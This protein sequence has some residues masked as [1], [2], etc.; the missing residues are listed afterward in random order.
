MASIEDTC[1]D[2]LE[3]HHQGPGGYDKGPDIAMLVMAEMSEGSVQT[4]SVSVARTL[5]R[6]QANAST[7]SI[8]LTPAINPLCLRLLPQ[9]PPEAIYGSALGVRNVHPSL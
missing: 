6:S 2:R 1:A 8:A 3:C 5:R 4:T 9:P 7:R